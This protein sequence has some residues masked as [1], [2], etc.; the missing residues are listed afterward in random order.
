MASCTNGDCTTFDTTQAQWFKIKEDGFDAAAGAWVQ[1]TVMNGQ[2]AYATIPSNLAPGQYM[3]RHEIIAL[4][5]ATSDG[6]AEFY[7]SCTQL[8][9]GGN[10]NAG[11]QASD[12]VSLPGAYSD[13]D[14]GILLNPYSAEGTTGYRFPGPQ[15]ASF[16]EGATGSTG[17]SNSGTGNSPSTTTTVDP[18]SV[19]T[20]TGTTTGQTSGGACRL[21]KMK[22]RAAMLN[23]TYTSHVQKRADALN[24]PR[25]VSRIMRGI[26][27]SSA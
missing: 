22:K 4:H 5:L 12:L 20:A 11:P 6:G 9:V 26:D 7:P 13:Q 24:R 3:V 8:E 27:L 19:P 21:K 2:P 1:Q 10:G 14:A 25:H 15:L 16:V 17:G 18:A 23:G